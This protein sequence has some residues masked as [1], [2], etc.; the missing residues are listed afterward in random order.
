MT[1][2]DTVA[3]W[4]RFAQDL[5][6]TWQGNTRSWYQHAS[7][8]R[9]FSD[10]EQLLQPTVF[11]QFANALLGFQVGKTLAPER[12]NREGKPDFTPADSITHPFVFEIKSTK[13]RHDFSDH[14][15]QIYRYLDEGHP[16]IRQV[17]V[18]NLV[19]VSIYSLEQD[20]TLSEEYTINL[21]ALLRSDEEAATNLADAERLTDFLRN[22]QWQ[23]LTPTQKLAS[24][25]QQ[26][27]WNPLIEVTDSDWI[28]TRLDHVVSTLTDDV[29]RQIS[30]GSLLD[31]AIVP[32]GDRNVIL[33]ELKEL[34]WRL[35]I[36]TQSMQNRTIEHYSNADPDRAA[37]KALHQF[38]GHVAYFT[39][40]RLLLVRVW[41]DL[42]LLDET[43]HDGGFD[44]WMYRLE[45]VVEHVV[46]HS[47]RLARER[48]R[49]LFEPRGAYSWYQP[50]K[51]SHAE[52]I[53]QLANTFLGEIE[54]D[55]L[56]EV[57]ERLLERVDRKLLGQYYTPRD[58]I[59]L[60]WD[61]VDLNALT[62]E[63]PEAGE[64][65]RILDIATGSGGFLVE[66]ASRLRERRKALI[67][68]GAD[69][70][71]TQRWLNDSAIGLVGA[72]IQRFPSFLAELN[73]LIQFGQA[74]SDE[75]QLK[76]PPLGILPTDTLSLHNTHQLIEEEAELDYTL[77]QHDPDRADLAKRVK[78]AVDDDFLFSAACGNPP[79]VGENL[80][81]DLMRRTRQRFPYWEQYAGH[82]MDYLYWFLILGIS[83][84]RKRGRFGFITTE[85]WLRA[86]GARPLRRYLSGRCRVDRIVLFRNFR[87]FPDAPGQHSLIIT[88]ERLVSP[89]GKG[90]EELPDDIAPPTISVYQGS[91]PRSDAERASVLEAIRDG[92]SAGQVRTFRSRRV[93]N[94]LGEESWSEVVLSP[95]QVQRRESLRGSISQL[96]LNPEQG[97]QTNADRMRAPY[98][99][100]LSQGTL[101]SIGWPQKRPGIF[102][103]APQEVADFESLT[104]EERNLLRTVVNTRD[105]F[106]YAAIPA[107]SAP[108]LI[109]LEPPEIGEQD[110]GPHVL[111]R[112]FPEELPHFK[113]HLERFRSL[114][115]RKVREYSE[116][117]RRPW[118]S[119]HRPKPQIMAF[120]D[121]QGRWADYAVTTRWGAGEQLRVGLAPRHSAPVSGI[122]ALLPNTDGS[123]P[124]S[125]V[126]AVMNATAVQELADTLPPGTVRSSDL[127]ELGVPYI[128]KEVNT[129]SQAGMDLA[130]L[131][132][133][134]VREHGRRFPNL[135]DELLADVSLSS[136]PYRA[137]LPLLGSDE[138][139]GPLPQLG[140]VQEY[141]RNGQRNS[142]IQDVKVE[143]D[144]LG[145]TVACSGIEGALRVVLPHGQY[146]NALLLA[147]A[148]R[149]A[150]SAGYRLGDVDSLSL[151]IYLERMNIL[152]DSDMNNL[153][154]DIEE[155][156]ALRTRVDELVDA[157]I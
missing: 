35:G 136:L 95:K 138:I 88:G 26:P 44:Q 70:G 130:E 18:T 54:S 41:E 139:C 129:I 154:S 37:G 101:Q 127:E 46:D 85:Y 146:Q 124:G 45:G 93:P 103:L 21:L 50:G 10:E 75:A 122:Y 111:H 38:A 144:L 74:L 131:V 63:A 49:S 152:Y 84:L 81:A 114:L 123:V 94:S 59:G 82:H 78:L 100:Y 6:V 142:R 128:E 9:G 79:Y 109:Y 105:L 97:V 48:Y 8:Q 87:L 32:P 150:A 22:F 2:R 96:S 17:V 99:E 113:Q 73:L 12:R 141:S 15:D 86:V 62:S 40:T 155:Y 157:A 104:T 80:G 145:I 83:K 121:G 33:D 53:Y 34:E 71:T 90:Q 107:E 24:V 57:Y 13:D 31:D 1:V 76:L 149:G 89:D 66:A 147:R 98:A 47:F 36:D 102:V 20:G 115:E 156:R 61:L 56:G 140:W 30:A 39:A 42:G 148:I 116:D 119:I 118:W 77:L 23:E 7:N 28:S 135:P 25:R 126:T 69:L 3:A 133:R 117:D 29:R 68:K 120:D 19:A 60:I 51:D 55:V 153:T 27:P 52:A 137:W 43:L 11:P 134:L 4:R 58:I 14:H 72:E 132:Y 91:Q 110:R 125:Y 5:T 143:E 92:R 67:A 65:P 16:R 106:P 64:S 108:Q 151:P 112:D